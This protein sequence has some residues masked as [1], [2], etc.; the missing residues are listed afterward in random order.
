MKNP[1]ATVPLGLK[2]DTGKTTLIAN[3][4]W[5]PPYIYGINYLSEGSP[6]AAN[7]DFMPENEYDETL[8]PEQLTFEYK[9]PDVAPRALGYEF[10]GW[11]S[12]DGYT[13]Q[14]GDTITEYAGQGVQN[15]YAQ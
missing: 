11:K 1:G 6:S 3:A 4:I 5:E 12:S 13:Y 7:V 10:Q 8:D 14:P 9:I 15:L 2:S